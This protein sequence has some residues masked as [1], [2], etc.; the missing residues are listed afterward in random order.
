MQ[1]PLYWDA[2]DVMDYHL[3]TRRIPPN[4]LTTQE[5]VNFGTGPI[6]GG[7][8]WGVE[9]GAGEEKSTFT[10]YTIMRADSPL[11]E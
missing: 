9:F 10:R 8:K 2:W 4:L 11:L 1:V 5:V 3:E 6:V 7:Y